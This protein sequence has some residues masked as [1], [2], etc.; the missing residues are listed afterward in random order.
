MEYFPSAECEV[1]ILF[2]V[3]RHGDDVGDALPHLVLSDVA[4]GGVGSSPGEEGGPAGPTERHLGVGVGQDQATAGQLVQ[5]GSFHLG[6][7]EVVALTQHTNVRSD[8]IS[9]SEKFVT[10]IKLEKVPICSNPVKAVSVY[11]P[12]STLKLIMAV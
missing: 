3:L 1:T 10:K 4:P 6:R 9:T 11:H 5:A 12:P 7:T 8:N 2:E